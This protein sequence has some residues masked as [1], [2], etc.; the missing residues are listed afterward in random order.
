LI[1]IVLIG[2]N[3]RS[4]T[5]ASFLVVGLTVK[6][7]LKSVHIYE[8]YRKIKPGVSLFGPLC[9]AIICDNRVMLSGEI[10]ASYQGCS[11]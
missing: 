1:V 8:S 5:M 3:D 9:I 10:S 2:I 6:K 4:T 11:Q 7:S